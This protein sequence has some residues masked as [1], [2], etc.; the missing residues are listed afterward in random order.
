ML[1]V[2]RWRSSFR[3]SEERKSTSDEVTLRLINIMAHN[4]GDTPR[5]YI[6]YH[7]LFV[8]C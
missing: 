4:L 5:G 1:N 3:V 6:T 2:G 8:N 7:F